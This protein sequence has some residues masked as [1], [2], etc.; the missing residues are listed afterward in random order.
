M[1]EL[2]ETLSDKL[3]ANFA[4]D[5]D[6]QADIR[7]LSQA[8]TEARDEL[9]TDYLESERARDAYLA[10]YLP[11][12]FEK[13]RTLLGAHAKELWPE[14]P[15][16]E[17]R[18]VDFG[19]GPGTATL[20][21]LGA[22]KLRFKE[23][24]LPAINVQLVDHQESARKLA[25]E[26]VRDFAKKAG[27]TVKIESHN[28]LPE[29]ARYDL[30]LAANVLNELPAAE[31][32]AQGEEGRE[33]LMKLWDQTEGAF[34]VLEPGHRV[35][36]QRLVRFRER[37]LKGDRAKTA[38]IGPCPHV[39]KCPVYRTK[40]WCHFSEPV[41][42]G[43]LIDLNLRIFRDKRSWLKFSYVLF[44]RGEPQVFDKRTFRAIGDVHISKGRDA[45]DLCQPNEKFVL[46]VP[47]NLPPLLKDNLV[48]G[49]SVRVGED[50]HLT[51]RALT[52]RK[53]P[54]K[55]RAG[56]KTIAKKDGPPKVKPLKR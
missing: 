19:C 50:R 26:L 48:R 51:A 53:A 15:K 4:E 46:Y 24:K 29:S 7:R 43:R 42:D 54:E 45:I 12:N 23:D 37:V 8:F 18:W 39:E 38:I 55:P 32:V 13:V 33:I 40:D 3:G 5:V 44:Q 31:D 10:Y 27:M 2:W 14:L 9:P 34:L 41:T 11:L 30:A 35:S 16:N 28:E 6:L 49:A 1:R 17:L 56:T 36:S 47:H 20:A 52:K 21:A 22:F 25:A